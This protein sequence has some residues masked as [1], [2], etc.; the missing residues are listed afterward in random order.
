MQSGNAGTPRHDGGNMKAIATQLQQ[1]LAATTESVYTE[2]SEK[3]THFACGRCQEERID[4]LAGKYSDLQD[5]I[6]QS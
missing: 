2:F 1:N 3:R 4:G 6:E 5:I